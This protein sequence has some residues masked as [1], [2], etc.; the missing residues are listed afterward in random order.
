MVAGRCAS[1]GRRGSRQPEHLGGDAVEEPR[2]ALLVAALQEE[3]PCHQALLGGQRR[4]PRCVGERR[5][6]LGD[7]PLAHAEAGEQRH[8]AAAALGRQV[9]PGAGVRGEVDG[10]RIPLQ[11]GH[12]TGE[13]VGPEAAVR[14]GHEV[15]GRGSARCAPTSCSLSHFLTVASARGRSACPPSCR[16]RAAPRR[17][18]G[19]GRRSPRSRSS[20]VRAPSAGRHRRPP[21]AARR[22]RRRSGARAA[23]R[24]RGHS[25]NRPS[26]GLT[27]TRRSAPT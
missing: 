20:L 9:R 10:R 22:A 17:A 6:L 11:A 12:D 24:A 8:E 5:D 19:R 26:T 16:A 4:L 7:G 23:G 3:D 14:E 25:A 21:A 1:L 27:S 2:V 15:P 18:R 13:E